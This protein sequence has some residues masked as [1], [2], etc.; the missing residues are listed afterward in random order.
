MN[1]L[2]R[3]NTSYSFHCIKKYSLNLIRK[4]LATIMKNKIFLI[5]DMY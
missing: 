2:Q 4:H 5:H 1:T 3:Q